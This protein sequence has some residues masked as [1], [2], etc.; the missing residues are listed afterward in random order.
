MWELD[1]KESWVPKNWCF[2]TVVLQKTLESPL[3]CKETQPV[4]PEGDQSWV[5]NGR[6]DVEA[7]MP[8][9][10]PPDAKSWLIWKDPDAGKDWEQEEKG[11]TEDEMVGW[12]HR[13]NGHGFGWTPAVGDEQG[14]LACCGSWGHNDSDWTEWL[15]W[16]ELMCVCILQPLKLPWVGLPWWC[17]DKESACYAGDMGWIPVSGRSPGEGNGNPLQY[18]CLGN[19]MGRG[20]WWAIVHVVAKSWTWLSKW[21]HTHTLVM[22]CNRVELTGRRRQWHPTP[23]LLPRKSHGGGAW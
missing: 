6:A 8:I 20:A 13:L 1:Y 7:E 23:V 4:H 17:N 11:T 22:K 10:W 19:P 12:H 18:S 15:N 9:L 16:N 5:F 2:W 21:A 14:G 3:D